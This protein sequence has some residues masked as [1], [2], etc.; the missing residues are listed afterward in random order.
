MTVKLELHVSSAIS[1][2]IE[3]AGNKIESANYFDELQE[4]ANDEV[5]GEAENACTYNADCEEIIQRY[6]SE[7]GSEAEELSDADGAQFKASE[8][9]KAMVQ[10]ARAIAD[11]AIRAMV[12]QEIESL[13]EAYTNL[14]ESFMDDEHFEDHDPIPVTV[15]TSCLYGWEAHDSE[16]A[17]GVMIWHRLEGELEARA[18]QCNGLWL[19]VCWT[20]AKA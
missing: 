14:C 18:I 16:T 3:S 17:E 13:K 19:S 12:Q 5:G 8:F 20:P 15:G 7:H 2:A 6:E 4:A 9:Q 11:C 10:Y 1:V